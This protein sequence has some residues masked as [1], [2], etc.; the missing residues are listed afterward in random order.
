MLFHK[1]LSV[2]LVMSC[3]ILVLSGCGVNDSQASDNQEPKVNP[4]TNL[5]P[6][7]LT[8]KLGGESLKA[9]RGVYSWSEGGAG[10]EASSEDPIN[11][12]KSSDPHPVNQETVIKLDFESEPDDYE[13]KIWHDPGL[14]E[15][16][17]DFDLSLQ[18]GEVVY[19]VLAH[20]PQGKASYA[21]KVLV[22]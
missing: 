21:F 15:R 11:I 4:E 10:I 5:E 20:W 2:Y 16:V 3:I 12:L 14:I 22:E 13:V 17:L 8:V 18:Q 9:K 19:E 1:G 6:P 7:Q